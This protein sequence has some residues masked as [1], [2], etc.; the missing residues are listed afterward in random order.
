MNPGPPR[1]TPGRMKTAKPVDWAEKKTKQNVIIDQRRFLWHD[2]TVEKLAAWMRLGQGIH[3]LDVGCGLGYLGRVFWKHFGQGG[4]YTG[5]DNSRPL[6][7]QALKE[8]SEW[9]GPG[10]ACF[11]CGDAVRLP[12]PDGTFDW[13]ACQTLLMHCTEPEA[14]L[15]EM[16][17]VTRPGGVV[18]CNEPDNVTAARART[19][20]SF[21][22]D[23]IEDEVIRIRVLHHWAA[24]RKQLG[25]GDYAIG[26]RVP[27][28]MQKLGLCDIDIRA[29]DMV[30]LVQPPYDTPSMHFRMEQMKRNIGELEKMG[31]KRF[32]MD[33]EFRRFFFAGGGTGHLWRKFLAMNRLS[34]ERDLKAMKEQIETLTLCSC[35]SSCSF[36]CIKG[37]KPE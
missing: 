10:N 31:T 24:G 12:F 26:N 30:G 22:E 29:N 23:T 15:A 32:R 11:A 21:H 33:R 25:H 1:S 18:S 8:S 36:F 7:K 14:V 20:Q 9:A 27:S 13:T 16:T 19:Y 5:L 6:L 34:G 17:R 37:R 3:A 2:D 35:G 28:M 4:T